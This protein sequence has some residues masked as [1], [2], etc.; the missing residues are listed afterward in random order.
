MDLGSPE[1]VQAQLADELRLIIARRLP[2]TFKDP[3]S[4]DAEKFPI[5]KRRIEELSPAVWE[6]DPPGALLVVARQAVRSLS[7]EKMPDTDISYRRA[8]EVLFGFAR[9]PPKSDGTRYTYADYREIVGKEARLSGVPRTVQRKVIVPVRLLVARALLD[10]TREQVEQDLL[11]DLIHERAPSASTGD[12]NVIERSSYQSQVVEQ[13][14]LG[15]RII[16]LWGEPGT[17]KTVL[18]GM[19]AS[20]LNAADVTLRAGDADILRDD[21]TEAL[22]AEGMEPTNWS[23]SYSRAMLKRRLSGENGEPRSRIVVLDNVDDE[24][25]IW[26]L[27]PRN[28]AV[29]VLVTMRTRPQSADI[30][31]VEIEDFTEDQARIFIINRLDGISEDEART[32]ARVLGCRPLALDHATRFLHESPDVDVPT[33]IDKLAT[34]VTGGLELVADRSNQTTRLVALYKIILSSV[35]PDDVARP[36]LD[37]FLGI[38]GKSGMSDRELLAFFM[39][40]EPGGALDRIQFRAGLRVLVPL[41]L[42]HENG[43]LL[44]MHPLTYEILRDLRGELPFGIEARY[45]AYVSSPE[46]ADLLPRGNLNR[47]SAYAWLMSQVLEVGR[48]GL[49]AGWQLLHVVDDFTWIALRAEEGDSYT[50]RYEV[51]PTGVYKRDYRTGMRTKVESDEAAQLF[52]AAK[53]YYARVQPLVEHYQSWADEQGSD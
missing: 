6:R 27:V 7:D 38:T 18:A 52:S 25:L 5:T 47:G 14:R 50:V 30:H 20:A 15:Y 26:Q 51:Y 46:V 12:V 4:S 43:K 11:F 41:G 31:T 42:I 22:I 2:E 32:L 1:P 39:Q 8:G 36:V 37:S 21:I 10:L 48:Q 40:S 17:G 23:D 33:L 44:V 53:Q 29:P 19:A 13:L 35:V 3:N 34:S 24:D 45:L 28:P 9:L 16:C 49:P